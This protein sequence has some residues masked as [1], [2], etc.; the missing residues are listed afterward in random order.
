MTHGVMYSIIILR[1]L[2]CQC[3]ILFV[4]IVPEEGYYYVWVGGLKG[5]VQEKDLTKQFEQYGTIRH[6]KIIRDPETKKS[7]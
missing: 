6:V 1:T 5:V 3:I 4:I 7:K 2:L